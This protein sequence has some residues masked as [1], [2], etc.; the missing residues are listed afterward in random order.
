M[1]GK[2]QMSW[3]PMRNVLLFAIPIWIVIGFLFFLFGCAPG[4]RLIFRPD[5]YISGNFSP[6]YPPLYEPYYPIK[7]IT[8]VNGTPL[9]LNIIIDGDR[10]AG[11]VL[12]GQHFKLELP[13]DYLVRREV[14]IVALAYKDKKLVGTTREN[15][16]QFYGNTRIIESETWIIR[17]TDIRDP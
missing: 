6:Y 17:L 13:V 3:R 15:R 10:L 11:T 8:I 2:P 1:H 9:E 4:D 5:V 16:V 7:T 14:S 12:A